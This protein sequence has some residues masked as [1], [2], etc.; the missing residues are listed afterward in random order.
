LSIGRTGVS[1]GL[2]FRNSAH[3]PEHRTRGCL[4]YY[5]RTDKP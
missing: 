1:L 4:D 3:V 2:P 5:Y